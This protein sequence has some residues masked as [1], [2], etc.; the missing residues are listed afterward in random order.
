MLL[1]HLKIENQVTE[2]KQLKVEI[3]KT[4]SSRP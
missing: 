3:Q 4:L 1:I 2:I